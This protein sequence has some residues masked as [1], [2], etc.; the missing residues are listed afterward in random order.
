VVKSAGTHAVDA[1]AAPEAVAAV[2]G[3]GADIADHRAQLLSHADLDAAGIVLV[4]ERAH[5]AHVVATAPDAFG[6]TFCLRELAARAE[7][8]GA[9]RAG[10]GFDEWLA[11]V[12]R[13][14]RASDVLRGGG[15][16]DVTDPIGQDRDAF[17]RCARELDELTRAVAPLVA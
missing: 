13:G 11:R 2:A 15:D 17:E 5:V 12:H 3:L 1:P 9:R 7:D 4:M 14:R 8:R 6:H 10:E 16:L